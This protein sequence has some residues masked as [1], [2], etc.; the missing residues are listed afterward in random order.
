[1]LYMSLT[2]PETVP[3]SLTNSK[4]SLILAQLWASP[5][6][7]GPWLKLYHSAHKQGIES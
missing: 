6:R 5:I 2:E 3:N 1:M 7:L 4:N